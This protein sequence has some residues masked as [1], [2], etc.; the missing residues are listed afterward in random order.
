[1][2]FHCYLVGQKMI[3]FNFGAM[4][5]EASCGKFL[6]ALSVNGVTPILASFP[7]LSI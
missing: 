6:E 7:H 1:M 2:N 4:K 5:V 3:P